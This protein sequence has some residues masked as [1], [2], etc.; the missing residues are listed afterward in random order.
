MSRRCAPT[1]KAIHPGWDIITEYEDERA[2][3]W[4]GMWVHPCGRTYQE[5]GVDGFTKDI[6]EFKCDCE[7]CAEF[8]GEFFCK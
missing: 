4:G 3:A 8:R 6:G 1:W 5:G 2:Y 7:L